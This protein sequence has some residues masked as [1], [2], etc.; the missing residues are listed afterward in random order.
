VFA[1]DI[2]IVRSV[3]DAG[4]CVKDWWENAGRRKKECSETPGIPLRASM[5]K[6]TGLQGGRP[7]I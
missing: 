3:E 2:I 1:N 4:M 7:E 6:N 5:R